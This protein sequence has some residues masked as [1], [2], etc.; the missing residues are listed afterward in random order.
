MRYT[1]IRAFGKTAKKVGDDFVPVDQQQAISLCQAGLIRATSRA[2]P[3]AAPEATATGRK[4]LGLRK[5]LR[6]PENKDAASQ[7]RIK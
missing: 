6:A 4:L 3:A 2:K 1:V 5:P 7:R